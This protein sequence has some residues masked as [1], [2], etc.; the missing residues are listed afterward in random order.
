M[1]DVGVA[2]QNNKQ[3]EEAAR[4]AAMVLDSAKTYSYK[5]LEADACRLLAFASFYADKYDVSIKLYGELHDELPDD[6]DIKAMLGK[7][8]LALDRVSEAK[9][10]L[11]D[12]LEDAT[13]AELTFSYGYL[14]RIGNYQQ[15]LEALEPL[16][17]QTD[18]EL[19]HSL[20]Q[21]FA[22]TLTDYFQA[23][24]QVKSL[25]LENARMSRTIIVIC[26]TFVLVILLSIA[27]HIYKRY[28]KEKK[29]HHVAT[30]EWQHE[31]AQHEA[32]LE[33]TKMNIRNL[34]SERY[35]TAN[36]FCQMYFN[37]YNAERRGDSLILAVESMMADFSNSQLAIE[38][39]GALLDRNFDNVFSRLMEDLPKLKIE[40][41][42]LFAYTAVG[43]SPG[44]IAKFLN[45]KT[46]FVYNHRRYLKAKIE[47]LSS[48]E[49]ELYL[50]LLG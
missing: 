16:L 12:S 15:A 28:V 4:W 8:L 6:R 20:D 47:R 32:K 9:S 48:A 3:Y 31:R 10:L 17:K 37:E 43:F 30:I 18:K 23:E 24:Q 46:E 22:Q 38:K 40:D 33:A 35:T 7:N 21:N 39:L 25:R 11:P 1:L 50:A 19:S 44:T 27:V 13:V 29:M 34:V 2:Y 5:E 26:S 36:H 45:K 49:K 41:Q 14:K 42:L